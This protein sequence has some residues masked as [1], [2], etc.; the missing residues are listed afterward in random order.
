MLPLIV[1]GSILSKFIAFS[2]LKIP[3]KIGLHLFMFK[4]RERERA[5]I[6]NVQATSICRGLL[7]S[8]VAQSAERLL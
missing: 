5:G 7:V 8:G 2:N 3:N 1:T 4:F 6:C